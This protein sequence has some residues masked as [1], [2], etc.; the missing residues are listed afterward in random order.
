M[1]RAERKMRYGQLPRITRATEFAIRYEPVP[2]ACHSN[3]IWN[4]DGTAEGSFLISFR[5]LVD[6]APWASSN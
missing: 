2:S 6:Y 5:S 4:K 1:E 3:V